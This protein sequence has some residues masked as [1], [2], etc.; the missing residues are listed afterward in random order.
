MHAHL[1]RGLEQGNTIPLPFAEDLATFPI[2]KLCFINPAI[3]VRNSR[4]SRGRLR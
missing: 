1:D 3:G 2:T 4:E